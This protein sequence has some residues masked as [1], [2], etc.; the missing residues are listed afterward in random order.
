MVVGPDRPGLQLPLEWAVAPLACRAIP[1]FLTL[2]IP[3]WFV[4][5][6]AASRDAE[7]PEMQAD[8]V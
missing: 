7:H 3:E 4:P 8:L 2:G 6:Q 5:L 1:I